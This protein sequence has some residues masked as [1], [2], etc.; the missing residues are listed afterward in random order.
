MISNY[1][2]VV[3]DGFRNIVSEMQDMAIGLR[4]Y[5]MHGHPLEIF[6]TLAEMDK[7]RTLKNNKYPL[8]ALFQD[9]EE[10]FG[11]Q[12]VYCEVN[13]RLI[14]ATVTQ[15]TIKASE[16]Y[17]ENFRNILYP[18]YARL[19]KEIELSTFFSYD[20][21]IPIPHTKID[22]LFWGASSQYGNTSNITTDFIDAIEINNLR[23]NVNFKNC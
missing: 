16:R 22:R 9:F 8:I 7:S 2:I 1:D 10:D 3:V 19:M 14:I 5:F 15:P 23:I 4:P 20:Y 13:L 11:K 18:I 21:S 12:N 6:S 17:N